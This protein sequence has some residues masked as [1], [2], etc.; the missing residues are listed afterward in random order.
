MKCQATSQ[1][2][3]KASMSAF[4]NTY[5]DV[6]IAGG[7]PASAA[8]AI[9]I[10]QMGWQVLV[11]ENQPE[12][13]GYGES[14]PPLSVNLVRD[15]LDVDNETDY[16]NIGVRLSLGNKIAWVDEQLEI[17]DFYTHP[18]GHGLRVDRRQFDRS[19]RQRA[20][21][22]GA[23][24]LLGAKFTACEPNPL[25]GW[26]VIAQY[27]DTSND[28]KSEEIQLNTRYL[29]DATGRQAS[30]ARAI[31]IDTQ[32][33]DK[34]CALLQ[35]YRSESQSFDADYTLLEA[36]ED[37]WWYSNVLPDGYHRIVAFHCD[38][39]LLASR[40]ASTS[41]G[42]SELLH[43]TRHIKSA[44]QQTRFSKCG[45][46]KMTSACSQRLNSFVGHGFVAI[47]DAAQ[48][49]DPLS[50]QGITKAL[51]SGV[52]AGQ[53]I[54]YA[55]K[56]AGSPIMID[57]YM[58]RYATTQENLWQRYQNHYRYFY[59]LQP[60]WPTAEFWRRRC[61]NSQSKH[62]LNVSARFI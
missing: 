11:L 5:W 35:L 10:A 42:F 21:V 15:L 36:T 61:V 38:R 6:V 7:G 32:R 59:Q 40:K 20:L 16:I 31:G 22:S 60:R 24:C 43:R 53:L 48:A 34:L 18:S 30:V 41:S 4:C 62:Y 13:Q 3:D 54:G 52:K 33:T 1:P 45:S 8:T 17:F 56:S 26:R 39:D 9:K 14:L 58:T 19:L 44:L 23:Q 49:Y 57:R 27:T 47:G 12:R 37:G 51:E 29:V 28:K 55:L 25:N 2:S 46:L 50:S